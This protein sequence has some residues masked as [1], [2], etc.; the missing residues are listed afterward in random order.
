[1]SEKMSSPFVAHVDTDEGWEHDDETGGLVLMLRDTP[2]SVGLWKPPHGHVQ[3]VVEYDLEADETL[4]VIA[5]AGE[6]RV[7]DGAP[8]ELRPGV[9]VALSRGVRLHW[10]VDG[11]FRELWVYS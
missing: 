2:V 11:D 10:R 4:V 8:I 6:L 5:G 1:M 7:D 9:V 3:H